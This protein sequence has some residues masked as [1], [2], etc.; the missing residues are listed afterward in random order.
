MPGRSE[1]GSALTRQWQK[2]ELR[3]KIKNIITT[4]LIMLSC[5]QVAHAQ[6]NRAALTPLDEERINNR[7]EVQLTQITGEVV[8]TWCYTSHVMGPGRGPKHKACALAC[9][10]GGVTLGIVDDKDVLYIAAKHRG[11]TG[12]K[13]LLT[14]FVAKRVKVICWVAKRGGCNV[15]KIKSV[16]EVAMKQSSGKPAATKQTSIK[17]LDLK[18]DHDH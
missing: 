13:E 9:A 7:P 6:T 2:G 17:E 18:H 14:P 16:E 3:M 4:L 5:I 1:I 8:D 11:Y 10:H 12:C 15:I